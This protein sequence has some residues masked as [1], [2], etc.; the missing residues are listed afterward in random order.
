MGVAPNKR[1]SISDAIMEKNNNNNKVGWLAV[2]QNNVI[3]YLVVSVRKIFVTKKY[4]FC[5]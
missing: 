2:Q 3:L 4:D 5:Q 1:I